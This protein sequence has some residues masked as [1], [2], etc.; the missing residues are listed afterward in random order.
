MAESLGEQ[1]NRRQLLA[2]D[3]SGKE[4]RLAQIKPLLTN[5]RDTA[6]PLFDIL[7]L[8]THKLYFRKSHTFYSYQGF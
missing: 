8:L 4:N 7:G 3:I 2:S 6:K 5:I 1:E